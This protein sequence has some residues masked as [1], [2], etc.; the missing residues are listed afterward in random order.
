M[1]PWHHLLALA[2]FG[3]GFASC[4]D[5]GRLA[6]GTGSETTNTITLAVLDEKGAPLAGAR[7]VVRDRN[8]TG[9]V[10]RS[11][12][13]TDASGRIQ[14]LLAQEGDWIEVVSGDTAGAMTEQREALSGERV[15]RLSR[16]SG[17]EMSGL[18]A[19]ELVTLPGLGRS[20]RSNAG[21]N[22]RFEGLPRG[23]ARLRVGASE[24]PVPLT[25]GVVGNVR[26]QSGVGIADWPLDGSLDSL[27]VRR[28][29]DAAG[30]VS[31]SVDSVAPIAAGR[32]THLTI[33]RQGLT[34]LPEGIGALGFLE[35]LSVSRNALSGLPPSLVGLT[36]LK[37]L[38]VVDN[39]LAA[40][41]DLVRQL[42]SLSILKLDSSGLDSVPEWIGELAQLRILR[43][44][45]NNLRALPASLT[46]LP[47]L[48]VLT[49]QSNPLLALPADFHRLDSLEEFWGA[50]H[51][52]VS[53][54]DSFAFLPSLRVLQLDY[55]PLARLPDNLGKM[56]TL[57][58]L[59][60][61]STPMRFLPISVTDLALEK[62]DVWNMPLC[63]LDPSLETWLDSLATT[64][65]RS[66]RTASCP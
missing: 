23:V 9:P 52:M 30:L 29:L 1:K 47:R 5:D 6:G 7:V 16:L 19:H 48:R 54:P 61:S 12:T 53:L 39:P 44:G 2:V 58:D 32:R 25:A 28:V 27:A 59:R 15:L 56:T 66:H 45:Q 18:R 31:V 60:I 41:P 13:F 57:R 51:A 64:D 20:V 63:E 38:R 36:K 33:E 3:I 62:L 4:T 22:A 35:F 26:V 37:E 42:D 21:G 17:L 34:F 8:E 10:T 11:V 65:W 55:G 50:H 49:V 46:S 14:H 43:L 40:F 24:S